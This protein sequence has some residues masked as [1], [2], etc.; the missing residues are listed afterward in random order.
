MEK[1]ALEANSMI[2]STALPGQVNPRKNCRYCLRFFHGSSQ[3]QP[4]PHFPPILVI[5]SF[6]FVE[7]IVLA[8]AAAVFLFCANSTRI[9]N[10]ILRLSLSALGC[11]A[12]IPGYA[13]SGTGSGLRSPLAPFRCHKKRSKCSAYAFPNEQ[14]A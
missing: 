11:T 1:R 3:P 10:P 2:I 13:I 14:P 12:V 9:R 6:F 7:S 5:I 4:G 8:V